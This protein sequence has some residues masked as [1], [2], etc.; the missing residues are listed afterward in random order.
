MGDKSKVGADFG[1]P[2]H[3][4]F[5][6]VNRSGVRPLILEALLFFAVATEVTEFFPLFLHVIK[7]FLQRERFLASFKTSLFLKG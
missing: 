3:I 7:M 6:S 1:Q 2:G 5:K 4:F